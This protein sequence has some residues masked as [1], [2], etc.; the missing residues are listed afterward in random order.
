MPPDGCTLRRPMALGRPSEADLRTTA[1]HIPSTRNSVSSASTP[2]RN[3]S[4]SSMIVPSQPV[5]A[6]DPGG[7]GWTRRF[8]WMMVPV[9]S[10]AL[11]AAGY[12]GYTTLTGSPIAGC[13]SDQLWDCSHVT[14]SRWS[15]V[16]LIPVSLPGAAVYAGVLAIIGCWLVTK[17]DTTR[18]RLAHGLV[19][20][21]LTALASGLWFTGLQA[22]YLHKL[23]K[24]CLLVHSMG[25]L[26]FLLVCG[27]RLVSWYR[28]WQI[29]IPAVVS[30]ILLAVTQAYGPAPQTFMV[31]QF[32][33][34]TAADDAVVERVPPVEF[35]PP[36]WDAPLDDFAILN[37]PALD[38][39][40]PAELSPAAVEGAQPPTVTLLR[41]IIADLPDEQN[42]P[43]SESDAA[44]L[45]AEPV[46][47]VNGHETPN[48]PPAESSNSVGTVNSDVGQVGDQLPVP[49]QTPLPE[50]P[51]SEP[52]PEAK[53]EAA[54]PPRPAR[55]I[56]FGGPA[57]NLK[58]NVYDR[59][60]LG[61]PDAPVVF[62]ELFD[63][64]CPHCRELN[65][66]I[67]EL[68]ALLGNQLAVL[69]IPVPLSNRC[70][71]HVVGTSPQHEH[72]CEVAR[73]AIAVWRLKP[74][75]FE[76]YHR[77]LSVP[78]IGRTAAEA[79]LEAERLVD[80]N[81][82]RA[83]LASNYISQFL[84]QHVTMYKMAG[85]GI[86]PKFYSDKIGI[87]GQVNSVDDLLRQIARA[88]G[89]TPT[90]GQARR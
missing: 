73:L 48:P 76:Q 2:L 12:L 26:L 29:S 65:Q 18:Q 52:K 16:L 49:T 9:A 27:A 1:R 63:Y 90:S 85:A 37:A 81:Q 64:G 83:I 32:G 31:E 45:N 23:C 70:N 43:I 68:R 35:A 89:I 33:Q 8:L 77:W 69:V 59:P 13:D 11:V 67:D 61:D 44:A 86:V 54:P 55:Y 42:P 34:P 10:V 39:G 25:V 14:K 46:L 66:R 75:S 3:R 51:A 36:T 62:I 15:S 19:F 5:E 47:P 78:A 24:W 57:W 4:D 84:D 71:P 40:Q 28:L 41:P 20:L 74:E 58:L 38:A 22:F 72:S 56:Q 82:L 21:S 88:H 87:T 50:E 79:R 6:S 80:P 30:V 7:P 60:I 53:T 17:C